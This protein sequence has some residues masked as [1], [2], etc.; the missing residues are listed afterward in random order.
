MKNNKLMGIAISFVG[1]I[2]CLILAFSSIGLLNVSAAGNKPVTDLWEISNTNSSVEVNAGGGMKLTLRNGVKATYAA[3]VDIRF[4]E[5]NLTFTNTD[6]GSFEID[7]A[8]EDRKGDEITNTVTVTKADDK[9]KFSLNDGEE[10]EI[11]LLEGNKL[12]LTFDEE[13]GKFS[14]NGT[15]FGDKAKEG[16]WPLFEM[17]FIPLNV[18]D[19]LVVLMTGLNGEDFGLDTSGIYILDDGKPYIY[20]PEE[21]NPDKLQ[22][23]YKYEFQF[24]A[25]DNIASVVTS[26]ITVSLSGGTIPEDEEDDYY[27][28]GDNN[29]I[30]F[31]KTGNY[32]LTIKATDQNE[33]S[34]EFTYNVEAVSED[35][36]APQY[37]QSRLDEY[38][39]LLD[40]LAK[41]VDMNEDVLLPLPFVTDNVAKPEF[42]KYKIRYWTPSSST[43]S[44]KT[45]NDQVLTMTMSGIGEYRFQIVPYDLA[46]N[47]IPYSDCPIFTMTIRDTTAPKI[48]VSS[49]FPEVGYLGI[50]MDLSSVSVTDA[51]TYQKNAT[52]EYYNEETSKWEEIELEGDSFT[53][54]KLGKY[55]Y[56]VSVTDAYLNKAESDYLEFEVVEPVEVNT[57]KEWFAENYI[58]V[59]FF[60]LAAVC[61]I[62][63]IVLIIIDAK[64]KKKE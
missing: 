56:K 38:Q 5:L 20:F 19:K 12:N 58:S 60:G 49:S 22:I 33:N 40:E 15:E 24:K 51:S 50:A 44:Y 54:E 11:A 8:G 53:P 9:F 36:E 42:M 37:D 18:S 64:A 3:D 48:T 59:I 14:A 43:P 32:V 6:F 35:T 2:C 16:E 39:Q 47:S 26:N 28:K 61:L 57:V 4:L 25:I 13:T 27:V 10:V 52:L 31:K 29:Q 41:T 7:F 63:I 21:K 62:A 1:A 46:G 55:R 23:G 30:T 17:S 34:Q 45:I